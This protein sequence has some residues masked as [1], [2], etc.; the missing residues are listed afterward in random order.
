MLSEQASLG[1]DAALEESLRLAVHE[2]GV[3]RESRCWDRMA[4]TAAAGSGAS[5]IVG[6]LLDDPADHLMRRVVAAWEN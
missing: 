1:G 3:L 2:E 5:S 6:A 4:L